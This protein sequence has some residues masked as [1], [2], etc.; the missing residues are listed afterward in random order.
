MTTFPSHGLTTAAALAWALLNLRWQRA[1][2]TVA[3]AIGLRLS[4][5]QDAALIQYIF[6]C[7]TLAAMAVCMAL[8]FVSLSKVGPLR[9]LAVAIAPHAH[10]L[11]IGIERPESTRPS[12][13]AFVPVFNQHIGASVVTL[14][15]RCMRP[16]GSIGVGVLAAERFRHM[17]GSIAPAMLRER[18]GQLA[19]G[20]GISQPVALMM[21]ETISAPLVFGW[22]KP[23]NRFRRHSRQRLIPGRLMR[24]WRTNS[25][26]CKGRT[27][28]CMSFSCLSKQCFSFTPASGGSRGEYG[29]NAKSAARI[30]P[31]R[32]AARR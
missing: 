17:S 10:L 4:R 32:P 31:S 3:L 23:I 22:R 20:L 1:I 8:T 6:C 12:I 30:L 21:S 13:P 11:P 27:T 5:Q 26:M 14:V 7:D 24:S 16:H 15:G 18:F 19:F 28:Q 2:L 25:R 29:E 9:P